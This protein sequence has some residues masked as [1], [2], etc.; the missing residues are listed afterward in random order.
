MN[1]PIQVLGI[2]RDGKFKLSVP[3]GRQEPYARLT[4]ISPQSAQAPESE[5]LDLGAYEGRA[6]MVRG[7]D[8]GSWFYAAEIIDVAGPILTAVI[9]RLSGI[10]RL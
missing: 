8:Q 3:S 1:L 5:E 7:Y 2:V 4:R 6:I 10:S 9:E